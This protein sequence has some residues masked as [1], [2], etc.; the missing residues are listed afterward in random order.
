M[1][2]IKHVLLLLLVFQL[3]KLNFLNTSAK[4]VGNRFLLLFILLAKK[5]V[6]E[7]KINYWNN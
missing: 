2:A 7:N 5:L 6:D 1:K 4:E 3:G